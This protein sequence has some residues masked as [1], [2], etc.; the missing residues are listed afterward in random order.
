[1]FIESSLTTSK[2][3]LKNPKVNSSKLNKWVIESHIIE[4]NEWTTPVHMNVDYKL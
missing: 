4:Y 2:K 1:M 3:T